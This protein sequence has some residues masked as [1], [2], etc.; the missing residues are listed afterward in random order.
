MNELLLRRRAMMGANRPTTTLKFFIPA[1]TEKEV[2]IQ[3]NGAKGWK[4]K[5]VNWGDGTYDI[6]PAYAN[7]QHTYAPASTAREIVVKIVGLLSSLSCTYTGITS[8]DVS[9]QPELTDLRCHDNQLT[10]LDV[11][12]CPKLTKLVCA[13]NKLTS[14]DVS[15]CP[16][17][18][19]LNCGRNPLT[20]LDCSHNPELQSLLSESCQ[21]TTLDVSNNP[22]LVTLYCY[23]N[24]LTA[25][26]VTKCTALTTLSCYSNQLTALDVTKCTALTKL[27]CYDNQLTALDVTKCT[28]LTTL[29]CYNN[30]LTTLDVSNNPALVTLYC[31]SNQL[32][33]LDVNNNPAL[34]TLYCYSNQLTALDVSNNPA[35]VT[36]YCH[37]NQLTALDVSKCPKISTLLC[38]NNKTFTEKIGGIDGFTRAIKQYQLWKSVGNYDLTGFTFDTD[39]CDLALE[40][41]G[42]VKV[43]ASI[44]KKQKYSKDW[45]N[46]GINSW[47]IK[48]AQ[49]EV[50]FEDGTVISDK[51]AYYEK[52]AQIV[53]DENLY[54]YP[55]LCKI[56]T[57]TFG[58]QETRDNYAT[59]KVLLY[60]SG[61]N[62]LWQNGRFTFGVETPTNHIDWKPSKSVHK[63]YVTTPLIKCR[64]VVSPNA[65]FYITVVSSRY[66][67]YDNRQRVICDNGELQVTNGAAIVSETTDSTT[68]Q[69]EYIVQF[70]IVN[71]VSQSYYGHIY[72]LYEDKYPDAENP[73]ETRVLTFE[74]VK[75]NS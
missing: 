47:S 26:D 64:I 21:L 62:S 57:P 74:E 61:N 10:T 31:Y 49:V 7:M 28:A 48:A 70:D 68:N 13:A 54:E 51:A 5:Y 59:H 55:Q 44:N 66:S 16:A 12:K 69:T 9:E 73:Y 46:N 71:Q 1:N 18:R 14:L 58:L 36:L 32:T 2:K 11:S 6:S 30:Q 15:L 25:L 19:N 40:T 43:N 41:D 53:K 27:S 4:T 3:S 22:A 65:S 60:D 39:T 56:H 8:L 50:H 52:I 24:Q 72:C 45:L 17:L 67:A 42:V 38:Y 34:V 33:A 23:S 63:N 20:S 75:E 37:S 29:S 35:L